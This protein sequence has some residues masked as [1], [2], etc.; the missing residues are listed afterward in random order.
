[1][2]SPTVT[3]SGDEPCLLSASMTSRKVS[4]PA[5]L[6]DSMTTSEPTSNSAMVSMAV[7]SDCWGVAVYS[8]PP[9]SWMISLTCMMS[10]RKF[11]IVE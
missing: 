4:M 1:M 6:P 10:L 8:V 9:L 2:T 5:I 7:A 3:P 11:V